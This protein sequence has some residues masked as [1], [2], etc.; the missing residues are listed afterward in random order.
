MG[1]FNNGILAIGK[2]AIEIE[3]DG[4]E[5]HGRKPPAHQCMGGASRETPRRRFESEATELLTSIGF[6]RAK[7]GIRLR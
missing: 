6:P 5:R 3:E 4:I 1:F 2:R 7:P